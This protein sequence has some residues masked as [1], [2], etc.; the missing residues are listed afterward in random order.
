M[1]KNESQPVRPGTLEDDFAALLAIREMPTYEPANK[2]FTV[3][4]LD[5]SL[6]AL[7]EAKKNVILAQQALDAARD[8]VTAAGW[9]FHNNMLDARNQVV[10]Q[11]GADS[12]EVQAVGLKRSS[13]RARPKA[14]GPA[15]PADGTATPDET[16][17]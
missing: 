2:K 6:A 17:K 12:L 13:E 15:A 14:K 7:D 9:S 10:A 11:Y 16:K 3:K 1:A 5:S 8:R 4:E